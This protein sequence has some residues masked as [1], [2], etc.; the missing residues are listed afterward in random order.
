MTDEQVP[1][2]ADV[3]R[4]F[5]AWHPGLDST[6][7]ARLMLQ[8]TLYRPENA[9]VDYSQAKEIAAFCGLDTADV[10]AFKPERLVVHELLIRITADFTVPDG[11]N[12]EAAEKYHFRMRFRLFLAVFAVDKGLPSSPHDMYLNMYKPL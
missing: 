1:N 3:A 9:F 11:P 8:V 6:I 12:Y 4:G 10:A 7:P 2:M 5:D